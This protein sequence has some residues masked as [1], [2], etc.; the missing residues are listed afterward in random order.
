[1]FEMKVFGA[2]MFRK[3]YPG[4]FPPNFIWMG[5]GD[6]DDH[7]KDTDA[8]KEARRLLDLPDNPHE[9]GCPEIGEY[10]P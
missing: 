8:A 3:L 4:V 5:P 10:Y 6:I 2:A 1:M 7:Y 9:L